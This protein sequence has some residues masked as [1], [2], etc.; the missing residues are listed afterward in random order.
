MA[1]ERTLS[2]LKPDA[3][4]RNLTGAINDRFERRGLRIV[5]QKR[6]MLTKAQAESFYEVHAE[7]PF[8]RGLVAFMISGPIVVQVL[9]GPDAVA[10]S[11]EIMGATDPAARR[12]GHDPQG[13]RRVDRGEFG[14]WLRFARERGAGD[15]L[16]L[17]GDRH[18]TLA[19]EASDLSRRRAAVPGR[20]PQPGPPWGAWRL[21]WR[22]VSTR[23]LCCSFRCS[24]WRRGASRRWPR[25]PGC[26]PPAWFYARTV[27][28]G[29]PVSPFR[30]C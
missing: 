7:R 8:Y 29:A 23:R 20:T 17:L 18:P 15:C 16:L 1:I 14:A 6:I 24:S 10:L 3:T 22:P 5:A 13:F 2:I 28:S 11:R 26:L 21:A 19:C 27:R 30:R 25:S 9:E 4:R 12:V